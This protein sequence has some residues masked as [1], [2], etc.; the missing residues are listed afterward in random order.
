M[1]N[2]WTRLLLTFTIVIAI[3]LGFDLID[4]VLKGITALIIK[5]IIFTT[6]VRIINT[7]S[8]WNFVWS[9][10]FITIGTLIPFVSWILNNPKSYVGIN[11]PA[12]TFFLVGSAALVVLFLTFSSLSF[13]IF[14]R[15]N[16]FI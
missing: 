14:P 9:S 10:F 11:D 6:V 3:S 12:N 13:L 4:G 1:K 7:S 2:K 8:F 16:N 5:A 15:T